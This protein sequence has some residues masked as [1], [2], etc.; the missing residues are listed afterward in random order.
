[1]MHPMMPPATGPTGAL[2][3]MFREATSSSGKQ[4]ETSKGQHLGEEAPFLLILT[5]SLLLGWR[6]LTHES[7]AVRIGTLCANDAPETLFLQGTIWLVQMSLAITVNCA[8][9]AV[10]HTEAVTGTQHRR[11]RLLKRIRLNE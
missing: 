8:P 3:I 2:L 1:M 4:T 6:S 5:D 9:L 10:Q 11:V 7:K